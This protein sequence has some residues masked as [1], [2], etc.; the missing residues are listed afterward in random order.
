MNNNINFFGFPPEIRLRIYTQL[1]VL[2]DGIDIQ[3][4]FDPLPPPLFR[5]GILGVCPQL[6]RVCNKVHGEA[7][8]LLCSQ[9]NFRFSLIFA[10]FDTGR[11]HIPP[12]L[13]Q[14]GSQISFIRHIRIEFASDCCSPDA[15]VCVHDLHINSIELIRDSCTNLN[16][17]EL[18]VDTDVGH[19]LQN[20]LNMANTLDFLDGHFKDLPSLKNTIANIYFFAGTRLSHHV[21]KKMLEPG[22]TIAI[23]QDPSW[24]EPEA[25]LEN[26]NDNGV[27][28]SSVSPDE[29]KD[30]DNIQVGRYD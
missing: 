6:L 14:I 7:A 4:P 23:H 9:N 12:F 13:S 30:G 21:T 2:E 19:L 3:V 24:D 17:L 1:L 8:A 5:S 10:A 18:S 20:P 26:D 15:L 28:M 25:R 22:W 29:V 27:S 16:T 11:T